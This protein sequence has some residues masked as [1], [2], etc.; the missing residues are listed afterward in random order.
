MPFMITMHTHTLSG[1]TDSGNFPHLTRQPDSLKY[2]NNIYLLQETPKTCSTKNV[3]LTWFKCNHQRF[4]KITS[5]TWNIEFFFRSHD[6][7]NSNNL[8]APPNY[9]LCCPK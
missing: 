8:N 3:T 5:M 7:I 1:H 6:F 2:T 4:K 9:G